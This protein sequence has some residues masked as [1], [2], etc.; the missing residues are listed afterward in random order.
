MSNQL[1]LKRLDLYSGLQ[2]I[3]CGRRDPEPDRPCAGN[4]TESPHRAVHLVA[5]IERHPEAKSIPGLLIFRLIDV[6]AEFKNQIR[7]RRPR[8]RRLKLV[9]EQFFLAPA[10]QNMKRRCW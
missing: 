10:A 3:Y 4:T 9:R 8:L 2:G 6:F 5:D 1:P 7:P